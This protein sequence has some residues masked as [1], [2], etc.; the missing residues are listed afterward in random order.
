VAFN[1]YFEIYRKGVAVSEG[2]LVYETT[3]DAQRSRRLSRDTLD[4]DGK[5]RT[6]WHSDWKN[7]AIEVYCHTDGI[8]KGT[9]AYVGRVI[10]KPGELYKLSTKNY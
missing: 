4:K 8:N 9:P 2:I 1:V 3:T 7:E 5:V 10:L 6:D